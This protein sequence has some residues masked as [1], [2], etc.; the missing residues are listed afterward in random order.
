MGSSDCDFVEEQMVMYNIDLAWHGT[1]T[2]HFRD[3]GGKG[4]G[5]WL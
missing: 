2:A 3:L 4:H 5:E 1:H